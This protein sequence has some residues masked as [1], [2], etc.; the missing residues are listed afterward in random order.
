MENFAKENNKG[1]AANYEEIHVFH[2][3]VARHSWHYF[4]K[5][6]YFYFEDRDEA[7][8]KG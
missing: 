2:L 8:H 3:W 5:Y 4:V 1:A 7:V 6:H